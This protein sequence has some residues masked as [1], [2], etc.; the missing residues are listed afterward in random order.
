[1]G[2]DGVLQIGEASVPYD[3]HPGDFVRIRT[4]FTAFNV[5]TAGLCAT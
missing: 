3:I 5:G 1:M 2:G 4:H